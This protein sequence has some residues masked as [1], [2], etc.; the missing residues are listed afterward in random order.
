[1]TTVTLSFTVDEKKKKEWKKAIIAFVNLGLMTI[2][3]GV[4]IFTAVIDF[5]VPNELWAATKVILLLL[6]GIIV[7][8]GLLAWDII[9]G[10]N[11]IEQKVKDIEESIKSMGGEDT[12]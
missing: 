2:I 11:I 3:A 5:P 8:I 12:K 7:I 9:A 6:A 1:M 10:I 4:F